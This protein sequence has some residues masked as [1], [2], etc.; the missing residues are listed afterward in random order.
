[1]KFYRID[2]R[3]F[4]HAYH[5]LCY[6]DKSSLPWRRIAD[7]RVDKLWMNMLEQY[8]KKQFGYIQ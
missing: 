4:L 3:L 2:D 1:M 8:M 5:H 7:Q 6:A